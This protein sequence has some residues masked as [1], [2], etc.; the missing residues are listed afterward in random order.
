MR[1]KLFRQIALDQRFFRRFVR[2]RRVGEQNFAFGAG[3]FAKQIFRLSRLISER[4]QAGVCRNF[5]DPAGKRSVVPAAKVS[6]LK[7]SSRKTDLDNFVNFFVTAKITRRNRRD[8]TLV[9]VKNL[10]ESR[11]VARQN[12]LD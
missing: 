7:K 12:K 6:E 3:Q 8:K 1:Q 11:F 2:L 5:A 9:A 4:V 10:F